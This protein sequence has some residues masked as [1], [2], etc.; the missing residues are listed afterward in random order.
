M[1]VD[2][3][4]KGIS[5][6]E[7]QEILEHVGI[8]PNTNVIPYDPARP[9]VA[10]GIRLGTPAVTR[11]GFSEEDMVIVANLIGDV[12]EASE[13]AQV[14]TRVRKEVQALTTAHPLFYE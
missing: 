3:R 5:G 4:D 11:R 14:A 13:D 1:L 10:S 12:L 8:A 9:A 7:A 2:L 6:R